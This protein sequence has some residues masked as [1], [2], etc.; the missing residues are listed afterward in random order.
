ML[1]DKLRLI[2]QK[3]KGTSKAIAEYL[4]SNSTNLSLLDVKDVARE[5]YTSQASV[6][7]PGHII[8]RLK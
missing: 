1:H 3:N 7:R 8:I 4:L 2:S 5:T 6:I